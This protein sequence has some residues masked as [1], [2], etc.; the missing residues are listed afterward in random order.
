MA[1]QRPRVLHLRGLDRRSREKLETWPGGKLVVHVTEMPIKCPVAPLEFAFLAD[2][3]FKEQGM[4]DKVEID[5]RDPARRRVHQ[6]DR[7]RGA[8]RHA[9]EEGHHRRAGLHDRA[10]RRETQDDRLVRR[11]ARCRSTCWSPSRST[12]VRTSSPVPGS[13][14]TS[15]SSPSTSAPCRPRRRE[16]LRPRRREQHPDLKGGLRRALRG[17]HLP[18]ELPPTRRGQGDDAQVRRA[19]QLLHRVGRRQ[20][21]C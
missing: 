16:H 5:L 13:A 11:D 19:R 9:R 12:W 18:G 21:A 14:T 10:R 17:R 20:G 7:G 2:A 3:Y 1:R 6:A 15:T 4:R 8:R